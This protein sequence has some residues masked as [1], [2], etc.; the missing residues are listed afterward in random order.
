MPKFSIIIPCFNGFNLMKKALESLENQA[1]KD[2]E[3]IIIDD[4]S[5]DGSF[6]KLIQYEKESCLKM[7][8]IQNEK[9]LGAGRTR[10]I[11]IENA[12]GKFVTFLDAD[13]FFEEDMLKVLNDIF[14]KEKV[15]A[16]IFDYFLK[17]K[18][19]V[20]KQK[21]LTKGKRGIVSKSDAL[22]YSNGSTWGKAYLL[23]NI[24]DNKIEFPNLQRNEDMPFNK[25]AISVSEAIFYCDKPMYY[26]VENE[27]S[28]MHNRNLLNEQYAVEA[29]ALLESK[30]KNEYYHEVEAIFLKEYLYAITMTLTAKKVK[31]NKIKQHIEN[32]LEKYPKVYQNE[33]IKYMTT[34]QKVC[35][36]AIQLK[37]VGLIKILLLVKYF[38]KK[39]R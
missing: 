10:N 6:E 24:K 29:F 19:N 26:Y 17:T 37:F 22:I 36:K 25:L 18:N 7:K 16:I 21:S 39:V 30:L 23:K 9:N 1:F 35:L 33:A 13:D 28:L 38:V 4:V 14:E 20:L 15:D 8:L 11:G 34:Y 32:A 2:F 31:S 27:E 5:T 12:I 3:V